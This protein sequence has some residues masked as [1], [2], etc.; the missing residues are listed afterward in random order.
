MGDIIKSAIANRLGEQS[1]YI[2]AGSQ[3]PVWEP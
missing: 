2:C 3:T 1:T